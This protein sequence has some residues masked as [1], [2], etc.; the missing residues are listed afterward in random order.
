MK[1]TVKS[2]SVT[3]SG[4]D[5][6]VDIETDRIK[7]HK[8][9]IWADERHPDIFEIARHLNKGLGE[10]L[11]TGA[12]IDITEYFDRMYVFI[13]TPVEYH[14]DQYSAEERVGW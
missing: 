4:T 8:Y 1:R 3:V 9:R 10:A 6:H 7:P 5:V 11:K 14:C 12:K 2:F 13:V